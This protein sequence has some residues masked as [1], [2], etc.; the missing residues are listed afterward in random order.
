MSYKQAR[1]WNGSYEN[2]WELSEEIYRIYSEEIGKMDIDSNTIYTIISRVGLGDKDKRYKNYTK[3]GRKILRILFDTNKMKFLKCIK[4]KK[5][6]LSYIVENK[7]GE[8]DLYGVRFS[9][10]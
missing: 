10:K 7:K 4:V 2:K 6:N 9:P 8:F 3:Y 1:I 5:D